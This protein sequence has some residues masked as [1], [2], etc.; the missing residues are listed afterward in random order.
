MLRV[1]VRARLV[2]GAGKHVADAR[3]VVHNNDQTTF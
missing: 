3:K 1:I 2:H